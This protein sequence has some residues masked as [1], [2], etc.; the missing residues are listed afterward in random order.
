MIKREEWLADRRKGIGGSDVGAILGFNPYKS[1]VEVYLDKIGELENKADNEAMYWGRTLEEV[2]AQEYA[3]RSENKIRRV[4][5]MLAH[6]DNAWMLANVDRE[7]LTDQRGIG[8]LEC[9]TANQYMV[10][11]WSDG[12]P[13][14]YLL[15]LMHYLAVTSY[16]WG[17]IAVLIGGRDFRIYDFA[18][19]DEL[20]TMM[21]ERESEFWHEHVLKKIPP[22][23]TGIDTALLA[24]LYPKD[25]GELI[26]LHDNEMG[27]AIMDWLLASE[28]IAPAEKRKEDAAAQIQAVMGKASRAIYQMPDEP[29]YGISWPYVKGRLAFNTKQFEADHPKLHAKYTYRG[30]GYRRFSIKVKKIQ[31]QIKGR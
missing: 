31:K 2:V 18:R 28:I 3:K 17:C 12:V 25:N 20:I 5:R 26:T 19:D 11:Q 14:M 16:S 13:E 23:A 29:V 10:D 4:N 21:I 9:K 24:R 15:Q 27:N 1:A 6:P 22:I 8:I 30:A 7:I